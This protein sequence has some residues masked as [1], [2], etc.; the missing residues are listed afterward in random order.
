MRVEYFLIF[1]IISVL[2]ISGCVSNS[3]SGPAGETDEQPTVKAGDTVKVSYVGTFED[4][5]V[6][7]STEQHGGTPLE[8]T[9]GMGQMISGFDNAVIGMKTGE[10]KNVRLE[11]SEAYGEH[12]PELVMEIPRTGVPEDV[13]VGDTLGMML[14]NGQQVPAKVTAMDTENVTI[15]MNNEMAGKVLIF[16]ITIVE[17]S[18]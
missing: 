10:E 17:F 14:A 9:V 2:I 8:F 16:K 18:S 6:F 13:E 15:D 3:D 4:G 12:R 11:P 1:G 7:D 5:T